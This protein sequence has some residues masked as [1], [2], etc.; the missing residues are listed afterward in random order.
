MG[1]VASLGAAARVVRQLYN[2]PMG[3][4]FPKRACLHLAVFVA[5][6]HLAATHA[7]RCVRLGV[8]SIFKI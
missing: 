3:G 2:R 7:R 8:I 4:E 5:R 6:G 1:R